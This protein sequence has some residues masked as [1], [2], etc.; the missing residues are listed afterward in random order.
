MRLLEWKRKHHYL[1]N[2]K[3]SYIVAPG[4]KHG[5][6]GAHHDAAMLF[7]SFSSSSS[8]FLFFFL[9]FFFSPSLT[10]Y[11][12]KSGHFTTYICI[13]VRTYQ[14]ITWFWFYFASSSP[15]L[16]CSLASNP[17]PLSTCLLF[18]WS[19]LDFGITPSP[20]PI[21]LLDSHLSFLVHCPLFYFFSYFLHTDSKPTAN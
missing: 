6:R 20:S 2:K 10:V 11:Q 19:F 17:R 9:N 1:T 12:L 8:S 14:I 13:Y 7:F 3:N 21:P 4:A 5:L 15:S 16:G 18:S